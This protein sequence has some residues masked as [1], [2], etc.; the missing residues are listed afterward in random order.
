MRNP[1]DSQTKAAGAQAR[2]P[3]DRRPTVG[4]RPGF[5]PTAMLAGASFLL[6]F[7]FL[8]F[9][10]SHGNDPA[11]GSAPASAPPKPARPVLIRRVVDTRVIPDR[12]TAGSGTA[13]SSGVASSGG[14]ASSEASTVTAPPVAAPAPAP[15][16]PV[17][18]SSS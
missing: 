18:S 15:A 5:W 17:V 16:A 6:L 10:L 7:E 9:Q 12:G 1:H 11:L 14:S 8:A 2:K 13:I 4:S 3:I